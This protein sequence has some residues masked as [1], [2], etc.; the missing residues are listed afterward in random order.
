MTNAKTTKTT[1]FSRVAELIHEKSKLAVNYNQGLNNALCAETRLLFN[2]LV[3]ED[4]IKTLGALSR[5]L[6]EKIGKNAKIE[7]QANKFLNRVKQLL[8]HTATG[9]IVQFPKLWD[10]LIKKL[11]DPKTGLRTKYSEGEIGN[12]GNWDTKRQDFTYPNPVSKKVQDEKNAEKAAKREAAKTE[13]ADSTIKSSKEV[14][15]GKAGAHEASAPKRPEVETLIERLA[16]M[17]KKDAKKW[18]EIFNAQITEDAKM[19]KAS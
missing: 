16:A 8:K 5:C 10:G 11:D 7:K 4:A 2:G 13:T 12:R 3:V 6:A 9:A 18:A 19:S 15:Q 14:S 1:D 17:T